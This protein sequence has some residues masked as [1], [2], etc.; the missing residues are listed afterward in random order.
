MPFFR[1]REW[2]SVIGPLA[3]GFLLLLCVVAATACFSAQRGLANAPVQRT[4]AIELQVARVLSLLQEAETGQR[5]Y[6]LTQD[7]SYL[8]PY[9]AAMRDVARE[10]DGLDKLVADPTQRAYLAALKKVVDDK[11]AELARTIERQR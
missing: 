3:V 10:M 5:G 1:L 4:T 7:E 11:F 2:R 6:L 9:E 8:R